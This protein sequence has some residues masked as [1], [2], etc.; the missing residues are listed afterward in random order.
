MIYLILQNLT[1]QKGVVA[2]THSHYSNN[3][4]SDS[5]NMY[6]INDNNDNNTYT[7]NNNPN[8]NHHTHNDSSHAIDR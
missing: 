7:N 4:A 8:N 3:D 6:N 2:P 5:N 1:L